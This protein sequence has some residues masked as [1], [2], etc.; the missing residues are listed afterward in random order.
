MTQST[1]NQPE[2][3]GIGIGSILDDPRTERRGIAFIV[4]LVSLLPLVVGAALQ[5]DHNGVGTHEQLGLPACN[6]LTVTGYPCVS[7]GMTTAVALATQGH[8]MQA[9]IVQPAGAILALSLAATIM[10]AGWCVITGASLKPLFRRLWKLPT[11]IV[12][13]AV[14]LGAWGYKVAVMNG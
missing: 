7:C 5:A 6:F 11:L 2:V 1:I 9:F 12:I 4:L 8:L 10:V 14:L 13:I 3:R